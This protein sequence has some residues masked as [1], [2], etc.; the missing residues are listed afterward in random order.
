M[1]RAV[2]VDDHAMFCRG[3][4]MIF[5]S[6]N[7]VRV[8]AATQLASEAAGI[9]E[10]AQPDLAL[11]DLHMPEI[12]GLGAIS[13]IKA[14]APEVTIVAL[15]GTTAIGEMVAALKEGAT[16]FLPKSGSAE[17]MI[18]PLQAIAD[19]WS[20]V[21]RPVLA[22]L[23]T[24]EKEP[25]PILATVTPDELEVWSMITHGL[26]DDD[27]AAHRACSDRTA[28][29]LVHNLLKVRLGGV[30][31]VQ[32]AARGGQLGLLAMPLAAATKFQD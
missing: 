5:N 24:L 11:V 21:P 13:E 27:I 10:V 2:V 26:T 4:E 30:T 12:G 1:I 16:S 18:P 15:S 20:I 17:K 31:R 8:V 7:V 22:M 14:A 6:G 9:C 32:A 3:L 19:G 23:T 29:R 28:K 25:D